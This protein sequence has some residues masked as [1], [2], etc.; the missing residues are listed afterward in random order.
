MPSPFFLL[1]V[2]EQLRFEQTAVPVGVLCDGWTAGQL[3]NQK[4]RGWGTQGVLAACLSGR[5]VLPILSV[6]K[7]S[8][9]LTSCDDDAYVLVCVWGQ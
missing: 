2:R 3:H 6:A 7:G 9:T 4:E 8:L 5:A 1:G